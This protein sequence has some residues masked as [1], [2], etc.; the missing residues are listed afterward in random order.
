MQLEQPKYL[1][2][3]VNPCWIENITNNFSYERIRWHH[4]DVGYLRRMH[5]QLQNKYNIELLQNRE[6]NRS[7]KLN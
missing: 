1:P 3:Y 2:E 6:E 7:E 5:L 4:H